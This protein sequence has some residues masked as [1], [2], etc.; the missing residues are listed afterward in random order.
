M[1]VVICEMNCRVTDPT[2]QKKIIGQLLE[3]GMCTKYW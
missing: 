3:K 2:K 1:Q